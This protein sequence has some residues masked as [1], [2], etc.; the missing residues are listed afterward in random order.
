MILDIMSEA[1]GLTNSLNIMSEVP[2]LINPLYTGRLFHC[3]ILDDP[4]VILGVLSLFHQ[5]YS[6]FDR[7]SY[8]QTVYTLIR[9]YH[10]V[11]T[12]LGLHCLPMKTH[13]PSL[14]FVKLVIVESDIR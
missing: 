9:C 3:Y 1:P 12:D 14:K 4:F 2:E 10:Y 8:K 6:I 7:K 13:L 5:F 11:A